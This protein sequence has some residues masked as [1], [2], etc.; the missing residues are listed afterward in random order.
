[1]RSIN[2]L[3]LRALLIGVAFSCLSTASFASI[4]V[5]SNKRSIVD[6]IQFSTAISPSP[7]SAY[8]DPSTTSFNQ[9][10]DYTVTENSNSIQALVTETSYAPTVGMPG[11]SLSGSGTVSST[12]ALSSSV[13]FTNVAE[14]VYDVTFKVTATADYALTANQF[15][16]NTSTVDGVMYLV[17]TTTKKDIALTVSSQ[18]PI[19]E[20]VTL[21]SSDTYSMYAFVDLNLFDYYLVGGNGTD[22]GAWSFD[23]EPVPEP[24]RSRC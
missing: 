10:L 17:D 8:A 21:N 13:L 20:I 15:S 23:L 19:N 1:M 4:V 6:H 22:T 16:S 12:Y 14:C 9:S 5:S 11:N 3:S 7:I 18:N 24:P 2:S